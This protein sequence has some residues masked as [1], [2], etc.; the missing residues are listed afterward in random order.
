MQIKINVIEL[1]T[2]AKSYLEDILNE[3]EIN[4]LIGDD[5]KE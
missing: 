4:N 5:Y 1:L 2:A 3:V